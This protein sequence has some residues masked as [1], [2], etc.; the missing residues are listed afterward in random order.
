MSKRTS[1]AVALSAVAL[2]G[3]TALPAASPAQSSC[4]NL[5]ATKKVKL[6]LRRAHKR[7]TS[8][9]FTGP[10]KGSLYY[11]RCGTTHYALASFKDA[12]F[13]Y[14]D[15]PERFRR[16]IHHRWKDFGDTG[17]DACGGPTP[18]ALLHLWGF[19]RC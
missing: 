9:P 2:A 14:Q 8:R 5:H 16:R 12:T 4:T 3:L 10:Q 15:Q 18:R 11:G 13:G 19:S 6:A 7:L 17:G 1:V